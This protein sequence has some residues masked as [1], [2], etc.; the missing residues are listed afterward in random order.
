MRTDAPQVTGEQLSRA[1]KTLKYNP[2]HPGALRVV[3]RG[4]FQT[5]YASLKPVIADPK[6]D[7]EAAWEAFEK[8]KEGTD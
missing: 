2:N 4:N 3:A 5:A 1:K 7:K 8:V 6:T